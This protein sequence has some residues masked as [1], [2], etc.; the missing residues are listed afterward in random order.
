ML[1]E[2]SLPMLGNAC[3]IPV[4]KGGQFITYTRCSRTVH[5]ISV[6]RRDA[7]YLAEVDVKM[8]VEFDGQRGAALILHKPQTEYIDGELMRRLEEDRDCIEFFKR[9]GYSLITDV[10][11]SPSYAMYLSAQSKTYLFQN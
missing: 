1:K 9:H 4:F 11:L 8:R 7:P 5:V 3:I 10:V 6:F 2:L